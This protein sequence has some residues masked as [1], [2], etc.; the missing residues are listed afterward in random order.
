MAFGAGWTRIGPVLASILAL[1]AA[2]ASVSRGIA[3]LAVYSLGLAGA[4]PAG[5]CLDRAVHAE[6]PCIWSSAAQDRAHQCAVLVI[7]IGLL[8][9]TGVFSDLARWA[10]ELP[11]PE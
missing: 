6:S 3:L 10:G 1:A 8:M 9:I 7:L 5:N 4:I 11:T 2:S